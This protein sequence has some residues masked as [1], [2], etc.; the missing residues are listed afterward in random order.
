MIIIFDLDDTLYPE[1]SYVKSGFLAVSN[2]LSL[3]YGFD[4]SQTYS[5]FLKTLRK[6]GREGIFNKFLKIKK[7]Y[8][9]NN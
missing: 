4:E 8:N 2:Y 3:K 7:V 6:D 5:F 9:K 1:I